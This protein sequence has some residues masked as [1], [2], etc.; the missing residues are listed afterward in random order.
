MK[1]TR[2]VDDLLIIEMILMNEMMII[3][4]MIIKMLMIE[5][6]LVLCYLVCFCS[7]GN[8]TPE[9]RESSESRCSIGNIPRG[10]RGTTFL[11]VAKTD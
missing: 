9:A 1:I 5:M 7:L 10:S 11:N 8:V 3:E 4:I 2:G 6:I